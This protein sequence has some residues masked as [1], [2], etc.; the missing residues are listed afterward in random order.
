MKGRGQR[1]RGREKGEMQERRRTTPKGERCSKVA[2]R[3][4]ERGNRCEGMRHW[5]GSWAPI[6]R[7]AAAPHLSTRAEIN[8][9][10]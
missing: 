5:W 9:G 8:T 1:E 2:V 7:R 6:N 10:T 4:T 3:A